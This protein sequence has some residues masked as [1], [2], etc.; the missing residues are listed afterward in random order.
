MNNEIYRLWLSESAKISR[1]KQHALLKEFGTAENIYNASLSDYTSLDFL[2]TAEINALCGKDTAAAEQS[3]CNLEKIGGWILTPDMPDYPDVLKT[4]YDPPTVLY[5]RG[6]RVD[7]NNTL[8]I[9][10]V[11]TR[12]CT[13]YGKNT[14]YTLAKSLGS[15]GVTI[16]SGMAL[17]IDTASHSGALAAHAPTVAVIGSGIDEPYP[18]SNARLMEEIAKGGMIMSEYPLGTKPVKYHFPE[19]NR[20]I[21]GISQGTLVIEADIKSGSLITAKLAYEQ[22]RDVFAVPGN[23]NSVYS[24]GTNYLLKDGAHLVTCDEDIMSYY[25]YDYADRLASTVESREK[26][27]K[28]EFERSIPDYPSGTPEAIISKI[29]SSEPV[30]IDKI[31]EKSR[32]DVGC[33]NSTL[34]LMELSGKVTRLPGNFYELK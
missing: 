7:L 26:I 33:V 27:F 16:I 29:I 21:S 23:I 5:C 6:M 8:C 12:K 4:I 19:R 14:A 3:L 2:T 34:L 18:R 25:R 10:S 11:G 24:K 30:N 20:I 22:G 17:G 13:T 31:C 32:L 1:H 9:A 15:Q 28:A